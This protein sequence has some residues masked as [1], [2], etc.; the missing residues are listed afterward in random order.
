MTSNLEEPQAFSI[1]NVDP[2]E[3]EIH[4]QEIEIH[5]FRADMPTRGLNLCMVH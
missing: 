1:S 2:I 3:I 5:Q 4:V